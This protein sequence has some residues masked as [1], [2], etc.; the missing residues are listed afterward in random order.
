MRSGSA[1]LC[2]GSAAPPIAE[3][4]HRLFEDCRS[5]RSAALPWP[6]VVLRCLG[7]LSL[8]PDPN[9]PTTGTSPRTAL[10]DPCLTSSRSP[11]TTALHP[12]MRSGQDSSFSLPLGLRSPQGPTLD[13]ASRMRGATARQPTIRGSEGASCRLSL[14]PTLGTPRT[15]AALPRAE[16]SHWLIRSHPA[17]WQEHVLCCGRPERRPARR[18]NRST[19]RHD[20]DRHNLDRDPVTRAGRGSA[21]AAPG[22]LNCSAQDGAALRS[23]RTTDPE[24]R[25]EGSPPFSS[26]RR[27]FTTS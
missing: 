21:T 14:P 22:D 24:R 11:P 8:R 12:P 1:P 15:P 25:R 19:R 26:A 6:I 7:P 17:R 9:E 10:H 4:Q 13:D 2:T 20:R 27:S 23:R 18:T 5:T 3:P 16:Q